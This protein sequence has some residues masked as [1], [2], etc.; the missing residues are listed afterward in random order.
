MH[1]PE[2]PYWIDEE[3]E[4][5]TPEALE[6]LRGMA[7][8]ANGYVGARLGWSPDVID[9]ESKSLRAVEGE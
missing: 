9:A 6:M 3:F 1:S 7:P 5:P 2:P 8:V 4:M